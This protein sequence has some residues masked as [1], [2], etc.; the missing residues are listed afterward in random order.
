MYLA[1]AGHKDARENPLEIGAHKALEMATIEGAR[2]LGWDREI[3]SIEEGKKA[4]LVLIDTRGIE[5]HPEGDPVTHLIYSASGSSVSTVIINGKLVMRD[6]KLMTIDEEELR[7]S[8][9]KVAKNLKR[10]AG[11]HVPWKWPIE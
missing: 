1:A 5:W 4:D 8:I 6:R 2:G 9:D 7:K 10:R 3:G 11:I